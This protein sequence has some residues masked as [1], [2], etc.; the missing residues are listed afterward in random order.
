MTNER[1]IKLAEK[2]GIHPSNFEADA[3]ISE[4]LNKLIELVIIECSDIAYDAY[5]D[6]PETVRGA[7]I[8]EQ[9]KEHFGVK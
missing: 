2:A 9:I 7:H 5:W 6:N 1:I 8:K 3:D 4:P